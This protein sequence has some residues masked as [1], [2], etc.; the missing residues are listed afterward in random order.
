MAVFK[1]V[2]S[3]INIKCKYELEELVVSFLPVQWQYDGY[4]CGLF[5]IA[6]AAEILDGASPINATFDV[7]EVRP[8]LICCLE[9]QNFTPLPKAS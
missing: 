6:F 2:D 9:I 7:K 4:N 3:L 1:C 8:H 5:A